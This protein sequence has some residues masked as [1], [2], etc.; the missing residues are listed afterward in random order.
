M[1]PKLTICV[2]L[3]SLAVA[4]PAGAT[5]I[6]DDFSDA[7]NES[8]IQS[9]VIDAAGTYTFDTTTV[10]GELTMTMSG[11]SA[12]KQEVLL[13]DDYNL[14]VG[15]TL[16]TDLTG[17]VAGTGGG[18][19]GLFISTATGITSREDVIWVMYDVKSGQVNGY[20]KHHDGST[21]VDVRVR[22][23]DAGFEETTVPDEL[24][25]D[26]TATNEY[27]VGFYVGTTR[28]TV[29]PITVDTTGDLCPGAAIGYFV[30]IRENSSAS[31]DDLRLIPEPSSLVLLACGLVGLLAYAW[32]KRK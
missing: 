5:I 7:L 31:F 13:R 6:V 19:V 26:R 32:R 20:H 23:E 4:V 24:Y 21:A 28:C 12:P 1:L 8:W 3:L 30:D 25:I 29:T 10:P 15:Y 16:L 9:T 18:G 27:E 11:Y 17:V 22:M 2:V 14:G